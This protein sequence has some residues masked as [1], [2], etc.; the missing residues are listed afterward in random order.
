[1]VLTTQ[2]DKEVTSVLCQPGPNERRSIAG[3]KKIKLKEATL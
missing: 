3:I 1:M 2:G